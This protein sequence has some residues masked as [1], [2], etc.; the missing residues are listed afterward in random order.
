MAIQ[1]STI[2]KSDLVAEQSGQIQSAGTSAQRVPAGI[3][4]L[5][6]PAASS[7]VN[8]HN[9]HC[10]TLNGST[11]AVIGRGSSPLTCA[12]III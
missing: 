1:T 10:Q 8:P 5:G 3:P 2:S 12:D 7:Y 9:T 4:S 6:N 11:A